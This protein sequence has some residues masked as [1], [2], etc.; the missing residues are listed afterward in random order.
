[1]GWYL[2]ALVLD[3]TEKQLEALIWP[4]LP[5]PTV[6]RCTSGGSYPEGNETTRATVRA[7]QRDPSW[8]EQGNEQSVGAFGRGARRRRF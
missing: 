2:T 4:L 7:H 8:V 6:A 1:M 5:G 3:K